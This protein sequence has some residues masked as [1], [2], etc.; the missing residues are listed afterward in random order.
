[1]RCDQC[2]PDSYNL[3]ASS[4]QGCTPC[5]C[6]TDGTVGGSTSCN[7]TNGQCECKP[8]VLGRT[9]NLCATHTYGLSADYEDGCRSCD[10]DATGTQRSSNGDVLV[11][12]QNSGACT[13]LANR[14][15]RICD[16]C[17]EGNCIGSL[18][19]Y[20]NII[21]VVCQL[22]INSVVKEMEIFLFDFS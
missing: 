10:C 1:M 18:C 17:T 20:C 9:C 22:R 6:N 2:A 14:V 3:Q 13:C 5:S 19:Q 21:V 12:D 16:Q 11:C 7:S 15:G 8:N 4:V